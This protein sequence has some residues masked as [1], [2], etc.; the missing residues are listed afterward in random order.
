MVYG[1]DPPQGYDIDHKN[2]DTLDNRIMNLR[3]ATRSEN[4]FNVPLRR[5]NTSGFRGVSFDTNRQKWEAYIMINRVKKNLGLYD[6]REE[7]IS[8]R[9]TAEMNAEIYIR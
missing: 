6:S 9:V 5:T 3:L 8:A 1:E 4:T 2:G 7:A